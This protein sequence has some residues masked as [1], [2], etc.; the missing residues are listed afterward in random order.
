MAYKATPEQRNERLRS[1]VIATREM[2]ESGDFEHI[3]IRKIAEKAGFHNSTIYSY[4]KDSEYLIALASVKAF[5]QYSRSLAELSSKN[6]SEYENFYEIW[7]VFCL[8]AFKFPEIYNHFFFGKHS[9]DLTSIFEEYYSIFPDEEQK[10]SDNIHNMYVGK[11]LNIRC[12]EILKPLANLGN[13]RL[14]ENNLT[15]ANN[16]IIASFKGFLEQALVCKSAD[17]PVMADELTS[18]F[19]DTLRFIIEK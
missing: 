9:D 16:L 18:Q 13:N 7:R 15:I 12:Y 19:M 5:E 1:F 3:H 17:N 11:N 8:N 10:L 6:L 4:F 2:I 14:S